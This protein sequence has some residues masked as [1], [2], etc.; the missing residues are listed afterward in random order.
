MVATGEATSTCQ[1][2]SVPEVHY[3]HDLISL[4]VD[5]NAPCFPDWTRHD[6]CSNCDAETTSP[7]ARYDQVSVERIQCDMECLQCCLRGTPCCQSLGKLD[8]SCDAACRCCLGHVAKF[9]SV[10][11]PCGFAITPISL[12]FDVCLWK[13]KYVFFVVC[14]GFII[15]TDSCGFVYHDSCLCAVNVNCVSCVMSMCVM[16]M[17]VMSCVCHVNVVS[18]QCLGGQ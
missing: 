14:S 1:C 7:N 15:L 4:Q 16:S 13:Y 8:E 10:S 2:S 5:F 9:G 17:C 12:V 11:I 18:C 3:Q 6:G